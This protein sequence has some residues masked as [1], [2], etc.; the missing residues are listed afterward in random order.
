MAVQPIQL[1][2]QQQIQALKSQHEEFVASL[3]QQPLSASA[4]QLAPRA[5]LEKAPPLST[6][7]GENRHT[8]KAWCINAII[9]AEKPKCLGFYKLRKIQVRSYSTFLWKDVSNLVTVLLVCNLLYNVCLLCIML[10]WLQ[11][12]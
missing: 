11:V 12:V 10:L 2:F 9:V 1:A 6:K 8:L 4:A 5:E 3:K 7:A